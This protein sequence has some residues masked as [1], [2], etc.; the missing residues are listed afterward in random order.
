MDTAYFTEDPDIKDIVHKAEQDMRGKHVSNIVD[1]DGHQYVDLVLEGCGV[2]GIALVGYT[3]VLEQAGLRFLGL[4]GTSTGSV[5]ALLLAA[6]GPAREAKSIR[7]IEM[8]SRID[9]ADFAD[10]DEDSRSFVESMI[11]PPPWP[12]LLRRVYRAALAY[13]S[14]EDTRGLNPG[15]YFLDWLIGIL[16]DHKIETNRD[17]AA[18]LQAAAPGLRLRDSD[19]PLSTRAASAR[20][21]IIAADVT[22]RTKAEFPR[23]AG[24]YWDRPDDVNPANFARA[25]ASIPFF[26]EPYVVKN[27]PRDPLAAIAWRKVFP[28]PVPD[29]VHFMDGGILSNFPIDLFH[30]A[31]MPN[32]PTFGARIAFDRTRIQKIE[33]PLGLA[34]AIFNATRQSLDYDF[35]HR[36]SDYR[37]LVATIDTGRQNWLNFRLS[38]QDKLE[39]FRNGAHAA[40]RF[41]KEFDWLDYRKT[42]ARREEHDPRNPVLS[43]IARFPEP[44]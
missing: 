11:E 19:L 7:L 14:I 25:C 12:A 21:A 38:D 6:V 8:L 3:Y 9:L 42:R 24:L 40:G 43:P 1:S 31:G 17:L 35:I 27:I 10:G 37:C 30:R 41:L 32:A 22:T 34:A 39:L 20:L 2:F 44:E 13:D 28:G 36:N 5:N 23:M 18:H 15:Q 29:Q 26:F 4:G 16:K 33:S